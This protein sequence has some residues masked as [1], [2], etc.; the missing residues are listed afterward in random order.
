MSATSHQLLD[1]GVPLNERYFSNEPARRGR[2]N[3]GRMLLAHR[4]ILPTPLAET[5][6]TPRGIQGVLF[7]ESL[8]TCELPSSKM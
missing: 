3:R 1:A 7:P 5:L 8:D 4:W 2:P 6:T